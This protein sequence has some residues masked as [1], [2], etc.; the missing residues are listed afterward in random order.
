MQ[1]KTPLGPEENMGAPLKIAVR[2]LEISNTKVLDI[3]GSI[4]SSNLQQFE[5]AII[6]IIA[7]VSSPGFTLILDLSKLTYINS[8]AITKL[9]T[10]YMGLIKRGGF[11][12]IVNPAK[13]IM[14]IFNLV[15]VNKV[16]KICK[17]I[18]EALPNS[19]S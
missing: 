14:D 1:R 10:G 13:S 19:K 11:M 15:G 4:D 3:D 5:K 2:N 17:D 6:E 8:T 16:V 9:M 18:N 7:K 12:K